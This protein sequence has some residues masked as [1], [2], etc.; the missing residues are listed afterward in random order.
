VIVVKS[1][2][3]HIHVQV[4]FLYTNFYTPRM[5]GFV[6]GDVAIRKPEQLLAAVA[7]TIERLPDKVA[8]LLLVRA[9]HIWVL[10]FASLPTSCLW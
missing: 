5:S 8:L 7:A 9:M 3:I 2:I 6:R 10:F 4:K 1:E